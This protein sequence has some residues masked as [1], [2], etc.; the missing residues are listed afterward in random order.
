MGEKEAKWLVLYVEQRFDHKLSQTVLRDALRNHIEHLCKRQTQS[1]SGTNIVY[2]E[3]V[4]QELQ[5]A[6]ALY[7]EVCRAVTDNYDVF[8]KPTRFRK[9]Y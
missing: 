3:Q 5:I 8:D 7:K 4:A 2:N 6:C 9:I 1:C